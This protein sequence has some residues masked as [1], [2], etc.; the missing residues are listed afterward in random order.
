M[1][2]VGGWEL[3]VVTS[4]WWLVFWFTKEADRA[5]HSGWDMLET[6][7]MGERFVLIR[8]GLHSTGMLLV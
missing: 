6:W 3:G 7:H 1:G 2:T 8:P 5:R 4:D